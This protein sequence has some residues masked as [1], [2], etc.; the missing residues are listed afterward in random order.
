MGCY[1]IGVSR[2]VAA[3]IEQSYDNDGIIWYPTIAPFSVYLLPIDFKDNEIKVVTE[4]IYNL[5]LSKNVEVLLDD[6][7]ERPGIKFK[8]ADLIGVPVRITISKKLLL[9]N[10]VEVC[11]R[12]TKEIRVAEI[13]KIYEE[14]CRIIELLK[15][16]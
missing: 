12:K 2:I 10:K 5:L 7:D 6:R 16:I 3:A 8:D 15:K 11:I 9:E 1:G 4:K 13:D 14:I